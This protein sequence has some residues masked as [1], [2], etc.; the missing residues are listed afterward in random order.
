M[1]HTEHLWIGFDGTYKLTDG[2]LEEVEIDGV[3]VLPT[4]ERV[5]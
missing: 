1:S 4:G 3:A 2:T 5:L